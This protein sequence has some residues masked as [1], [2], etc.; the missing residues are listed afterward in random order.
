MRDALD[1][2]PLAFP[3]PP[4]EPPLPVL[5]AG[6]AG[7]MLWGGAAWWTATGKTAVGAAWRMRLLLVI[8]LVA[9]EAGSASYLLWRL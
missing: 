6:A 9:Q 8:G 5:V 1:A 7:G 3:L 2:H 4:Q